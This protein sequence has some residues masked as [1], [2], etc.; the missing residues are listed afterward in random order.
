MFSYQKNTKCVVK[1][2]KIKIEY[3]PP[4]LHAG[5]G[6]VECALQTLKILIIANLEDKIGLTESIN[7]PFRVMRFA[8]H[9]GL[10][11]SPFELHEARKLRTELT[12]RIKDN[13]SKLSD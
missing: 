4:R 3:N 10:K 5:T 11:V 2:K 1:I 13:K 6:A 9:T 12:D 8:I 7:W